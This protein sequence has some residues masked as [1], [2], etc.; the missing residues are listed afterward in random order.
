[1]AEAK[2]ALS[3]VRDAWDTAAQLGTLKGLLF[4]LALAAFLDVAAQYLG[5][6][7]LISLDWKTPLPGPGVLLLA[8]AAFVSTPLLIASFIQGV[9]EYLVGF[10]LQRILRNQRGVVKFGDD[11]MLPSRLRDIALFEKDSQL[12]E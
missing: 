12:T 5:L 8:L 10:R 1:M 3:M 6:G 9:L 2:T 11:D 7:N 4:I